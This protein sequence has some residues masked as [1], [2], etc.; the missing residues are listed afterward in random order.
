MSLETIHMCN[1]IKSPAHNSPLRG[2]EAS[3]P[4]KWRDRADRTPPDKTDIYHTHLHRYILRIERKRGR[5]NE[6]E[7]ER[8]RERARERRASRTRRGFLEF[9]V[10]TNLFAWTVKKERE[11]IEAGD[12]PTNGEDTT[13]ISLH[14]SKKDSVHF[15]CNWQRYQAITTWIIINKSAKYF[16]GLKDKCDPFKIIKTKQK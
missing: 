8:E 7:R 13:D 5:V 10:E 12:W 9:F 11:P 1:S 4:H 14:V 15:F 3:M 16:V 2:N 6:K